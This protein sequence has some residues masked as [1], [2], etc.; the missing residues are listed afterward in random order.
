MQT[1]NTQGR[2]ALESISFT[3]LGSAWSRFVFPAVLH[4]YSNCGEML[5]DN[6]NKGDKWKK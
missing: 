5:P 6:P 4:S 2:V 1:G 3:A